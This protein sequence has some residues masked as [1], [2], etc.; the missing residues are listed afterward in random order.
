[1]VSAMCVMM[2]GII[3]K[4]LTRKFKIKTVFGQD[5]PRSMQETVSR[6]LRH[7]IK[8]EEIDEE[9]LS[10]LSD[11]VKD[12]YDYSSKKNGFGRLP[13]L[14]LADGGITQIKAIKAAIR[15]IEKETGL[16]LNIN[17]YGM[18]KNDKHQTR[19]LIGEDRV[20]KE[21]SEELFLL[22][23][24]FQD[25]VHEAAIGYHKML[26]DQSMSKSSLDDIKGI[27]EAKKKALLKHFESIKKI[28][29]ASIEELTSIKGIDEKLA[30]LLKNEL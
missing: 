6:R 22:I 3:K 13:D 24:R 17:V 26:R 21:I 25:T 10:K 4:N 16:D 12:K 19:A 15:E 27:G 11:E 9:H 14:I 2:D 5:D 7:S 28:K 23:T 30:K 20:E 29:E 1:M 18:V 8:L